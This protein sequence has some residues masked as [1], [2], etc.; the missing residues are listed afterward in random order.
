[1][2]AT[3]PHIALLAH[4]TRDELRRYLDVSEA[5]NGFGNRFLW[6]C[7]RRARE[8]PDGGN[9]VNLNA[10]IEQLRGA[11]AWAREHGGELRRDPTAGR[12][13]HRVYGP[14]SAGLPGMLGMMTARAEAQVMRLAGL[15]AV[16]ACSQTI[17]PP[18]LVAA[19]EVWRYCFSSAAYIFGAALGHPTADELSIDSCGRVCGGHGS[20]RTAAMR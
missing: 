3:A 14:L 20:C 4:I 13:W 1:M 8:L 16:A 10:E 19:L 5:A 11:A 7:V 6:A 9:E 18:H 17:A 2:R 15:Y 12:L